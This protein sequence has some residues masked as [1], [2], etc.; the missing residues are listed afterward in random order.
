M[1]DTETSRLIRRAPRLQG[2]DPEILPQELTGLY[3]ELVSLRLREDE[4][5][6]APERARVLERLSRIATIYEVCA[7]ISSDIETRRASAF[8]AA[9]AHQ[10]LGKVMTEIYGGERTFLSMDAI[11]PLLAAPLLF[12][13]AEQNADAR[14][15]ALGLTGISDENVIKAAL[16]ETVFDL[17]SE[18]YQSILDRA[19][20]LTFL[21]ASAEELAD[22]AIEQALYGL[23][24]A[25]TV[26]MVARLMG[27]EPPA[28]QFRVLA[29]PQAAFDRVIDL[30]VEMA[31]DLSSLVVFGGPRHLAALLRHLSDGLD[32]AGVATIPPPNDAQG[33][34]W[35]SWLRHRAKSKPVL[36]DNHRRAIATGLLNHG[37]SAV[38]VLPTGAGKTTLSELKIA[39]T[40]ALGQKV[41]FLVPTLAL[42]DQLRDDLAESFP[43][44]IGAIEVAADGDLM[45]MFATPQLSSIEVMTPERCLALM[46][47]ASDAL[48]D[49]G[50]VVFDECHLLS[51]QGGGTRSLDAMLCLLQAIRRAPSA[52][53]LL[54]SAMLTNADELAN[55][56]A[57]LM[58]RPCVAFV[59]PWKPSRQ[60]RGVVIYNSDEIQEIR[61][62]HIRARRATV[63]SNGP[64]PKLKKD[65]IPFALFGLHQ[66][67]NAQAPAD[68]RLIKLS[69]APVRLTVNKGL[70][71][72]PNSNQVASRLA[73]DA[74]V[75]GLKTI[76]FVQQPRYAVSTARQIADELE[77]AYELTAAGAAIWTDIQAELGG[78]QYSLVSPGKAALPHN[79]DMTALERRLA[80]SIFRQN[81]GASVIVATPTLA[82]G[83]NL[84]A[85]VAILAG[86]K[87]HDDDEGRA[88]LKAHEILNAAGRAGRAGYLA[89]GMVLLIPE[90][91]ASFS[92]E[93]VPE[94][95][96]FAKL[97]S[98]LPTDDKCVLIEDPITR[99]LDRIQAGDVTGLDVRY[100]IS[101]I[102]A[103]EN[104]EQAAENAI[105]L[106]RGSFSRYLA[107][108]QNA[109]DAFEAKVSA[110]QAIIS[111]PTDLAVTVSATAAS[112][113]LTPE[114]LAAARERMIAQFDA[115]PTT[116]TGW[117]EWLIDFFAENR[118]AFTALL[119]RD[120]STALY[121]MRGNKQGGPPTAAEFQGLKEAILL[122]LRGKTFYTVERR[123][124]AADNAIDCCPR[125]RDLILKLC[126]R[127]FYLIFSALAEMAT[128]LYTE[129]EQACPQ[130]SVL[131]TL[132]VAV[133]KGFDT[134]Q[135]IAF[136]HAQTTKMSRVRTH[137]AFAQKVTNPPVLAG[138][139]F[140]V[141][142][143]QIE[144]RLLFADISNIPN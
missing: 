60:A 120:A 121:V 37:T 48:D 17:A 128:A 30:S 111:Q 25:A 124:G 78:G 14:E 110:L 75:A 131:E 39:S 96:A 10:I 132:A 103:A 112:H 53:F 49:V 104:P 115:L 68:I 12:L 23:C 62:S 77:A 69:D 95:D 100:F 2:V 94:A 84:P 15:A 29:T 71:A 116:T 81:G 87:R 20:R 21:R 11:H 119:E 26:Q 51:P 63:K 22:N 108:K 127:R 123:L 46:S 130:P 44:T 5:S 140:E 79:G 86:D 70:Y 82:Q 102:Q 88:D 101:R 113:G 114:P 73:I 118:G 90:P 126:T 36:W 98:I 99:V 50:L 76:V 34:F 105:S 67:W 56:L 6:S 133:R 106:V 18:S 142:L 64:K 19:G 91:V 72:S 24:W 45:G 85:Q 93:N 136:D 134:P 107:A 65:V 97:K 32:G 80:E 143:D 35:S 55:W 43:A 40:L 125:T 13:V 66:N 138:Q 27:V 74:A 57:E 8:V 83:M 31:P 9:T 38:L 41:V 58:E 135:K 59:D 28:T 4:L 139:T 117:A 129:K 122:W 47:H 137:A 33:N 141:L 89:N 109:A 16:I 61:R 7:D 52:D 144:T 1:F 3:A 92:A 54:L 42:V